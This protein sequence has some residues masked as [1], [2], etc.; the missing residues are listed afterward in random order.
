MKEE[1]NTP[2]EV[3][4][5]A[6]RL[7]EHEAIF[8]IISKCTQM[9]YVICDND[10]YDDEILIFEDAESAKKVKEEL[11][12]DQNPVFIGKVERAKQLLFYT[13]LYTMGVNAFV[14]NRGTK[15]EMQI[16]ME[17]FLAKPDSDKLPDG[18]VWIENPELHLTALYFVQELRKEEEPDITEEL[19][20]LRE[21]VLVDFMRGTYVIATSGDKGLPFL[22]QK[23][24][25][26][27]QPVFTDIMEFNK[28]NAKKQFKPAMI[29]AEKLSEI[30][31]PE[32]KG[33]VVNPIGV[34]LPLQIQ[35][36]KQEKK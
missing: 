26:V 29:E 23:N 3:L 1:M 18:K 2:E 13:T 33:V 22:K 14:V 32:A 5:L 27:Y 19:S 12:A 7:R 16:Q 35:K 34:N 28:F 9:P 11:E 4:E 31:A 17:D 25:D 8:T 36:K 20:K 10:T 24:G 15:Q 30:M 6:R 21:E